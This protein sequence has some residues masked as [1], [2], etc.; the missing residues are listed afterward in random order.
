MHK[1]Q[2]ESISKFSQVNE[3]D[4]SNI[5]TNGETVSYLQNIGK[6]MLNDLKEFINRVTMWTEGK[7][8]ILQQI[9]FLTQLMKSLPQ[10]SGQCFSSLRNIREK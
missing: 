6:T 1:G 8:L 10:S 9:N 5:V 2:K 4:L 7:N 3:N